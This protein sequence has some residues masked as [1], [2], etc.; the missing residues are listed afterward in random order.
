MLM[1]ILK[2]FHAPLP[3]LYVWLLKQPERRVIEMIVC[4]LPERKPEVNMLFFLHRWCS[5][6]RTVMMSMVYLA[7]IQERIK[8]F[9]VNQRDA[10]CHLVSSEKGGPW[11][12]CD[13][14]YLS[15]TYL[16]DRWTHHEPGMG[17]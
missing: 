9:R 13:L 2:K 8:V 1:H 3:L 4:N 7:F 15:S 11:E 17:C 10:S 12:R 5:S 16:P 14:P 6:F